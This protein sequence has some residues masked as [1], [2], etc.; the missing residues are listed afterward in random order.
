[1]P[2]IIGFIFVPGQLLSSVGASFPYVS[3]RFQ[4]WVVVFVHRQLLH[5]GG[6][7]GEWLWG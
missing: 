6:G 4:M 5:G 3:G 1:M 2:F 7:G